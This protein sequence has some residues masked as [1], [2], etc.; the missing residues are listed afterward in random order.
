MTEEQIKELAVEKYGN[1]LHSFGQQRDGYVEGFKIAMEL[2][3][4]KADNW[5]E[6]VEGIGACYVN[7]DG[8]ENTDP[9]IDLCTIGEIATTATGWL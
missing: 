7:E 8:S 6:L 3:K 4:V 5:D 9:D 2:F 1:D